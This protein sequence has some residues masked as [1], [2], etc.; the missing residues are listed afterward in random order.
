MDYGVFHK[1]ALKYGYEN[2]VPD[3]KFYEWSLL[4]KDIKKIIINYIPDKQSNITVTNQ[5]IF[6]LY[7]TRTPSNELLS[8]AK[9][10]VNSDNIIWCKHIMKLITPNH[11]KTFSIDQ[12]IYYWSLRWYVINGFIYEK[13]IPYTVIPCDKYI[14][15]M[16]IDY[17]LYIK[18]HVDIQYYMK[19]VVANFTKFTHFDVLDSLSWMDKLEINPREIIKYISSQFNNNLLVF[20][21]TKYNYKITINQALSWVYNMRNPEKIL[22]ILDSKPTKDD[23]NKI[24]TKCNFDNR[25]KLIQQEPFRSN[26][27]TNYDKIKYCAMALKYIPFDINQFD[28]L[29]GSL[30]FCT[31]LNY[32]LKL[33][34]KEHIS[35]LIPS[36]GY[37]F[38]V[39]LKTMNARWPDEFK[40]IAPKFISTHLN[41]CISMYG[42]Y[43]TWIKFFE[44]DLGEYTESISKVFI[45][46]AYRKVECN[47]NNPSLC[48]YFCLNNQKY[49]DDLEVVKIILERNEPEYLDALFKYYQNKQSVLEDIIS[50]IN[51]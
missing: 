11:I 37:M 32:V 4:P 35:N 47:I 10:A 7:H 8:M 31:H 1:Y 19:N 6:T 26:I 13:Y 17:V 22:D 14:E 49:M 25:I 28:K 24:L 51:E 15:S 36:N 33:A 42:N 27:N 40:T 30:N 39:I 29:R 38:E 2:A 34:N 41:V 20:I 50:K 3:T 9:D 46:H 23:F 16:D 48:Y 5:E 43:S 21:H 18:E 45:N 44:I 12:K